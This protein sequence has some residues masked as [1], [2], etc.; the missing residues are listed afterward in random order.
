[1]NNGDIKETR[2]MKNTGKGLYETVPGLMDTVRGILGR[3]TDINGYGRISGGFAMC[4]DIQEQEDS[5]IVTVVSGVQSDCED[6]THVD[7]FVIEKSSLPVPEKE[8]AIAKKGIACLRCR[9]DVKVHWVYTTTGL[10]HDTAAPSFV[11]TDNAFPKAECGCNYSAGEYPLVT[12]S[13][14]ADIK[15]LVDMYD[16]EIDCDEESDDEER[17]GTHE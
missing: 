17:D 11:D 15:H 4:R 2:K 8:D 13:D 6:R 9:E 1:M 7:T 5:Y 12:K 10:N 16:I 3:V 14:Y